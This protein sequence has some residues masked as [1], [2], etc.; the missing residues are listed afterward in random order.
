[1]GTWNGNF[2]CCCDQLD[3]KFPSWTWIHSSHAGD[4]TLCFHYF[5]RFA[6]LLYW[7]RLVQSPGNQEQNHRRNYCTIQTK[8]LIQNWKIFPK[9]NFSSTHPHVGKKPF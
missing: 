7:L 4:W 2:S 5:H 8:S 3:C 1:M 9:Q 6:N